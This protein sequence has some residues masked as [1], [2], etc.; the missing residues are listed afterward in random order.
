MKKTFITSMLAIAISLYAEVDLLDK[1]NIDK[2]I[3]VEFGEH[4]DKIDKIDATKWYLSCTDEPL[5]NKIKDDDFAL[6]ELADK[7][8]P[9]V[10]KLIKDSQSMIEETITVKQ[11]VYLEKYDFKNQRFPLS[12]NY[13]FRT[14]PQKGFGGDKFAKHHTLKKIFGST[15]E[16]YAMRVAPPE[17]YSYRDKFLNMEKANAKKFLNGKNFKQVE[18]FMQYTIKIT[19][20]DSPVLFTSRDMST[21]SMGTRKFDKAEILGNIIKAEL[22]DVNNNVLQTYNY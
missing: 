14:T 19:K 11:Q 8:Y 6:E 1:S 13:K 9:E 21:V 4:I 15:T 16:E 22:L 12:I 3:M 18:V 2:L 7:Y 17:N 5:F 10:I 20:V